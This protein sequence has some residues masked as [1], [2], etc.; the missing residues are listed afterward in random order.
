MADNKNIARYIKSL[1][2]PLN[3][4]AKEVYYSMYGY[5]SSWAEEHGYEVKKE[6]GDWEYAPTKVC[7]YK[8]GVK[9]DFYKHC[10]GVSLSCG[11]YI[12]G[13]WYHMTTIDEHIDEIVENG[14]E[15]GKDYVRSD[16]AIE[17][18][19]KITEVYNNCKNVVNSS[20]G[21]GEIGGRMRSNG[22]Y[23][24]Y[25][26]GS[27]CQFSKDFL[28]M[29]AHTN[30]YP[31]SGWHIEDYVMVY[32]GDGSLSER[33][34][35]T[36]ERRG[37]NLEKDFEAIFGSEIEEFGRFYTE[38]ELFEMGK[39]TYKRFRVRFA[40]PREL[41]TLK[42]FDNF[43]DAKKFAYETA[44]KN[45]EGVT[46]D[47]RRY[48]YTHPIDYADMTDTLC[49]YLWYKYDKGSEHIIFVQGED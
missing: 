19:K 9:F 38:R 13:K 32:F 4:H 20:G 47:R 10:D 18:I 42:Y 44:K 14:Y 46:D 24:T 2:A 22:C 15:G 33:F 36:D 39:K 27:V 30:E 17:Q 43:E 28:A 35:M 37:F 8:G 12:N 40:I 48:A 25:D 41:G 23:V 1:Y 34:Y 31:K 45:A 26:G 11:C 21:W 7:A 3:A 16:K 5:P 6:K 29:S 49:A